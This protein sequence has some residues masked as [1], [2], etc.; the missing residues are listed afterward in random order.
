[1]L[2]LAHPGEFTGQPSLSPQ[3]NSFPQMLSRSHSVCRLRIRSSI[4]DIGNEI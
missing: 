1:M 2:V 4:N 3:K